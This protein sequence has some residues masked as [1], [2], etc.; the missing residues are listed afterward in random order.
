MRE[1][2]LVEVWDLAKG[3]FEVVSGG[4]EVNERYRRRTV[5]C[6][7]TADRAGTFQRI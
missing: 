6:E 4:E 2:D 3:G 7:Y 1:L 5:A